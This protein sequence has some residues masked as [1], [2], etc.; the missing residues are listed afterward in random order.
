MR[1]ALKE[2]LKACDDVALTIDIWSDRKMRGYLGV[3]GHYVDKD[4][5]LKS[6]L[7]ACDRIQGKIG[8]FTVFLRCIGIIMP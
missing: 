2:S 1:T 7:L 3:T 8:S 5:G 4:T 6:A